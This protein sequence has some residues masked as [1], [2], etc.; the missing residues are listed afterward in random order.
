MGDFDCDKIMEGVNKRL[1]DLFP[2]ATDLNLYPSSDTWAEAQM[3]DKEKIAYFQQLYHRAITS[4]FTEQKQRRQLRETL[5]GRIELL[6]IAVR[7]LRPFWWI[8]ER[9]WKR[10]KIK[11]EK[12]YYDEMD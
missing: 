2:I 4:L 3:S 6:E 8:V 7:K 5:D 1:S 9:E 12:E 11:K 10:L